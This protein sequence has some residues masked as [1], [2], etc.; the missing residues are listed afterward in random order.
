MKKSK[1]EFLINDFFGRKDQW[2][3]NPVSI[4]GEETVSVV[5]GIVLSGKEGN[6]KFSIPEGSARVNLKRLSKSRIH[7]MGEIITPSNG[8]FPMPFSKV[9]VKL[10]K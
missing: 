3:E 2:M 10:V 9:R 8:V 6:F 1:V 4:L 5:T 7:A